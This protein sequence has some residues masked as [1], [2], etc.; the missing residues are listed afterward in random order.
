MITVPGSWKS[1]EELEENVTLDELMA[2]LSK[3]RDMR[4]EERK[5]LAGLQGHR[6]DAGD[7]G[8][9]DEL[10]PVERA[11]RRV[12]NKIAAETGGLTEDE[13]EIQSIGFNIVKE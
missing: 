5:F 12:A 3:A 8:E 11:K 4:F 6:L 9:D 7:S 10:D 2:V 13:A 1:L